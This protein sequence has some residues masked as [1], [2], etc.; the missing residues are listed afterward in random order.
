METSTP[1]R[2]PARGPS[3]PGRSPTRVRPTA[4]SNSPGGNSSPRR[5]PPSP[6]RQQQLFGGELM[7][8]LLKEIGFNVPVPRAAAS[9][10]PPGS[11][12]VDGRATPLRMRRLVGDAAPSPP[13]PEPRQ[14]AKKAKSLAW[15]QKLEAGPSASGAGGAAASRLKQP[16]SGGLKAKLKRGGS[17]PRAPPA[18]FS[19]RCTLAGEQTFRTGLRTYW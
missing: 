6:V 1:Q 13:S 10:A 18:T 12:A 4:Y 17:P 2:S 7:E 15:S 9:L 8:Q 16:G 14:A 3:S 5:G 19:A 11:R